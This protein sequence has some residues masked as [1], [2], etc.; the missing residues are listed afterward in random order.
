MPIRYTPLVN[1]QLYHIMNR[2]ISEQLLFPSIKEYGR[3]ADLIGY[4]IYDNPPSTYSRFL[5]LSNAERKRILANLADKNNRL[6][7][8]IAFCL[9]PT[10][11]HLLL[12]QKKNNGISK[13]IAIITNS[14][15]KYHNL[16]IQ[17]QGPLYKGSFKAVRITT[18]EQLLHVTRYIHLN[19]YTSYVVKNIDDLLKY[20]HSSLQEY[21]NI[22]ETKIVE[23][24]IVLS[25]FQNKESFK[26]FHL[27]QAD[28]QRKLQEIK[29][30]V[31]E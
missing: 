20:P 11:F 9:M 18:D 16:K 6:V 25:N 7:G 28:Y 12:Q 22:T 1:N 19:P 3:F 15:A 27:D 5:K 23:K 30:L 10:H 17:R 13:F 31:L 2:S 8:I 26:K 4:Y 24:D 14:Y 21:L 29:H